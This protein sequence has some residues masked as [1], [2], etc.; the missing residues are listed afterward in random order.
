[1]DSIDDVGQNE[2]QP[3]ALDLGKGG[4]GGSTDLIFPS[5]S[6]RPFPM[7]LKDD[8]STG[9]R[10]AG[11][12]S[13]SPLRSHIFSLATEMDHKPKAYG[14]FGFTGPFE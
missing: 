13:S 4:G 1:M 10:K 11:I 2:N 9:L 8:Y 14:Q 6:I 12:L 7:A 5:R 3:P